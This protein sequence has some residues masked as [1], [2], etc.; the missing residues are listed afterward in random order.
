MRGHQPALASGW[1]VIA[2]EPAALVAHGGVCEEGGRNLGFRLPL[3]G[4][5]SIRLAE[6]GRPP[7]GS[8]TSENGMAPRDIRPG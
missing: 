3:L 5:I 1:A 2:E 6:C 7:S 4:K 8:A